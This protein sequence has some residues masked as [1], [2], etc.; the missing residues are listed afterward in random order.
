M[1][2]PAAK[3]DVLGLG[4]VAVDDIVYLDS[5][6]KPDTKN[7]IHHRERQCGGQTGTAL[8]AA[9]RLGANCSYA[10]VL[11]EDE[12]SKLALDNFRREN[13]DVDHV[14]INP[15][16]RPVRT[17]ILVDQSQQTRTILSDISGCYPIPEEAISEGVILS[18]RVLFVDH[19]GIE[20]MTRAAKIARESNIPI[21]ADLERDEWPGFDGLLE[22]VDHLIINQAF[23]QKLTGCVNPQESLKKLWHNSRSVVII[24]CGE[25]G[26]WFLSQEQKSPVFHPAF[27]IN[28]VDTTGCGDVFHG[29]YAVTLANGNSLHYRIRF[30]AAAAA[31][32]AT[33]RGGQKGIPT[34]QQVLSFLKDRE[35]ID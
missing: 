13:V 31:L 22:L 33:Q 17:V 3:Y 4:C 6:P 32:K 21:V 20:G 18:T 28:P 5:F 15:Q 7:R 16:A 24:T 2:L 9:A 26:C 11:G 19:Y 27:A 25:Q 30:A 34:R 8:V 10:G 14:V 35:Q 29:A 12:Y 23:A 1:T